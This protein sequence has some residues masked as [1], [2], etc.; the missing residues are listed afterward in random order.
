MSATDG[1][2]TTDTTTGTT[3]GPV[4]DPI[5]G[6][7]SEISD[8]L[9]AWSGPYVTDML[10][11]AWGAAEQDYQA[12]QGPLTAGTSTLQD[13]AFQG[14]GSL[15]TPVQSAFNNQ[16]FT[17]AGIAQQYMNPY[18]QQALDPQIADAQRQAQIQML[19]NNARL[20]K[21][22]AYGGGRQAIM[23]SQNQAELLR[24]I[25]NITGQGYRDAYN[26]AQGQFN[27]EQNLGMQANQQNNALAQ[28]IL[29]DQLSAGATQRGITSEGIAADMA[30][31]EEERDYPYKAAQ[32][33]QSMLQGLPIAAQS[34]SY[35]EPTDAQTW[36]S[37]LAGIMALY[38]DW[39]TNAPTN[40]TSGETGA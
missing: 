1:T 11:K 35:E 12:Y 32:Y 4:N 27:A 8:S 36:L 19:Q 20:T 17:D 16:S 6:K 30:Q 37:S 28:K 25:S 29:A 40:N 13:T 33:M 21:A 23:D 38:D 14:L 39:T 3:T 9:S 7:T 18:L 24:N 34:Y 2:T 10:G 5:L 22:G 31:F 15:E 26:N